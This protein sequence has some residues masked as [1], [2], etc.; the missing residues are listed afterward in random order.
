VPLHLRN[1][2]TKLMKDLEYGKG[3]QYAHDEAEGVAG[4]ECLPPSLAGRK[5]YRPTDRGFEKEIK[6]RLDGW[7]KIKADRR[8][9]D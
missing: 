4:M 6:R 5:Y 3:Y 2:P 7:E 8:R 9:G 1:A